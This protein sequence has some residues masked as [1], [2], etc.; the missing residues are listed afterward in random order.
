MNLLRKA[1][2]LLLSLLL[3][4]AVL[5]LVV[6]GPVIVRQDENGVAFDAGAP[7]REIGRLLEGVRTGGF[8]QYT[9]GRTLRSLAAD[10]PLYFGRSLWLALAGGLATLAVGLVCGLLLSGRSTAWVKEA[11]GLLG[12]V[13]DFLLA[14]LLQLLVLGIYQATGLK[15]ARVA[16]LGGSRPA[17]FLPVLTITLSA[18]VYLVRSVH[19]T[20]CRMRAQD[21]LLFARSLGFSRRA[22]LL[23]HLLPG[24][25]HHL[26][27]DLYKVAGIILGSLFIIERIFNVPGLTALLFRFSYYQAWDFDLLRLVTHSQINVLLVAFAGLAGVYFLLLGLLRGICILGERLLA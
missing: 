18:G 25:L 19:D 20:A 24:S 23:R 10:F 27:A 1:M 6:S 4:A 9:A 14:M 13:P 26:N 17:L 8:L 2:G 7:L 11:L 16:S 21:H 5:L 15:V 22:L 3:L 12:M